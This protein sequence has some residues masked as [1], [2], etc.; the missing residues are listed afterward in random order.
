MKKRNLIVANWKMNPSTFLEA[1]KVFDSVRLG[2]K[3]IKNTDIVICPPFPYIYPFVKLNSPKNIFFGAQNISSEL[4]GSFTGEVSSEM[5]KTLPAKYVILGHSERRTMGETNELVKKK[6]QIAFDT[7]LTPVLCIGE[8]ERD[9]N[10]NYLEFIKNQIKECLTGLQKKNLVGIIVAYEPIWA[11]GK[12]YKE[13]MS[14]TDIHETVLFIKKVLSELFGS[15]I[16]GGSKIL[17][18]GSVEAGNVAEIVRLGNV[19]GLLVGHA[20]LVP[21]EFSAILK[22][23]DLK[24]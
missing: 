18:G 23:V 10:G 14:P 3:G 4:K 11:I 24:R 1:K 13:S 7:D 12:S 9:K 6:M 15:D 19:D 2:A 20:S 17:Y 5:I 8:K 21:S 16:A 22:A